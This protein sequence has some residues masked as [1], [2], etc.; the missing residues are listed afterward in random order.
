MT[1]LIVAKRYARALLEIGKDDGNMEKYGQE[2]ASVAGLFAESA[3]L[4]QVLANPAI[5]FEDRSRLLDTFLDKLQL[6]PIVNNFF[7]LLMD[8]GRIA[9]ARDISAVYARLLDEEKG[10]TRAE[11]VSAAPLGEGEVTRLKEVL[12]EMAGS[13]VI[14][15]IKEDSSLIGGVRA[16]IGDL[17]LDGTIKTQL[18]TLK[19]SLRRG[20]YA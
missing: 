15:E 11:V 6:S 13:E 16:K 19:D 12:A 4:E 20:D 7:R 14:V 18:E 5:G 17:V 2:L 10:I 8:R 9:S 3:E 1:S